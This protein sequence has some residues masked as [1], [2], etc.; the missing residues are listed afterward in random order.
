MLYNQEQRKSD[1]ISNNVGVIFAKRLQDEK[2]KSKDQILEKTI[3]SFQNAVNQEPDNFEA[4]Y[5]LGLIYQRTGRS[6]ESITH[7]EKAMKLKPLDHIHKL[8]ATEYFKLGNTEKAKEHA[9]EYIKS[10]LEKIK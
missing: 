2:V 4:N 8:L 10:R 6:K 3:E 5:N 1:K 9:K 7:L